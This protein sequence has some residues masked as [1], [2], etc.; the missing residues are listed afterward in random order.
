[1]ILIIG[2]GLEPSSYVPLANEIQK[3][4]SYKVWVGI[5]SFL[6]NMPDPLTI[7]TNIE[8]ILKEMGSLG[9]KTNTI[10]YELIL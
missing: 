8:N 6:A 9:M 1:L 10:F 4:S 7:N 3:A 5:P 2:A